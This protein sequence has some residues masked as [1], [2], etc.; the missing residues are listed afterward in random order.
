MTKQ[1]TKS[2]AKVEQKSVGALNQFESTIAQLRKD[3]EELANLHVNVDSDI[4]RLSN[5]KENIVTRIANN[6]A[7]ITGLERVLRGE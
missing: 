6:Q 7:A 4:E 5:L 3:N 1:H 2:F